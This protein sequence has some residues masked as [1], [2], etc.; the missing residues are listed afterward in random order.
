MLSWGL[1]FN[2][3]IFARNYIFLKNYITSERSVSHNV[4]YHKQLS[5]ANN[6]FRLL[7][8]MSSAFNK[9]EKNVN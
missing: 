3:N 6:Y 1:E 2:A 4:L 9:T 8:L 5:I 7:P